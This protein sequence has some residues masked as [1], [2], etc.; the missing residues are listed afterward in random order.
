MA[1]S[2]WLCYGDASHPIAAGIGFS[3]HPELQRWLRK[4]MDV[5]DEMQ[6]GSAPTSQ[7]SP[8]TFIKVRPTNTL[9]MLIF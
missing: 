6:I 9:Y 4:W 2:V 1:V 3:P 8:V 5:R 7:C